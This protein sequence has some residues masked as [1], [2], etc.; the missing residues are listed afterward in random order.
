MN[1]PTTDLYPLVR[2]LT[3]AEYGSCSSDTIFGSFSLKELAVPTTTPRPLPSPDRATQEKYHRSNN[4]LAPSRK[5]SFSRKNLP[6]LISPSNSYDNKDD[7]S[8]RERMEERE[9][10]FEDSFVLTRQVKVL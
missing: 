4:F 6:Q 1:L 3:E 2:D 7:E 8:E 5:N 9:L 10:E